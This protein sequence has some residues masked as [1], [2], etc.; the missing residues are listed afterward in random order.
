[1]RR[2]RVL[3]LLQTATV[4]TRPYC[5]LEIMLAIRMRKPIVAVSLTGTLHDYNFAHAQDFLSHLDERLD[6]HDALHQH[7]LSAR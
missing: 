5:L 6:A 1:M 3:V 7:R 2:S 4:L